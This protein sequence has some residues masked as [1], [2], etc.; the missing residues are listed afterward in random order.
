MSTAPKSPPPPPA[1]LQKLAVERVRR[2]LAGRLQRGGIRTS[3][4]EWYFQSESGK[5]ES[6]AGGWQVRLRTWRHWS[7]ARIHL[8][9]DSGEVLY[10]CIDRFAE[11]PTDAELTQNEAER[12]AATLIPI[13]PDARVR[14]FSHEQFADGHKVARLEWD[15]FHRDLRVDGDYL[16]VQI[17]P[18][19][20]RLVAFGRKWRDLR[21]R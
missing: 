13:P 20:H 18:Q 21:Q 4:P 14:L 9:A 17:Q 3:R 2:L 15:H 1:D 5:P 7:D 16:W 12:I 19:S 6:Y 11:P 8:D 10:R